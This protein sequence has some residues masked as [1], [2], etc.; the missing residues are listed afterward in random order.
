MSRREMRGMRRVE[1]DRQ[2]AHARGLI[3]V[4]FITPSEQS[5][6]F[7]GSSMCSMC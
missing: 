7:P 5:S 4:A 3:D 1:R 2:Y 6:T